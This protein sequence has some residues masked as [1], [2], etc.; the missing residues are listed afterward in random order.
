MMKKWL[1]VPALLLLTSC[2]ATEKSSFEPVVLYRNET[3]DGIK[4]G[5]KIAVE[6]KTITYEGQSKVVNGEIITPD[7]SCKVGKVFEIEMP[8]IYEVRYRAFFGTHEEKISIFYHCHRTSGDFFIPSDKNNPALSGEYSHPVNTGVIK[9]AKLLLDSKTT[10]TYDG[11]IDF[12][13]LDPNKS[14]IEFIVDTSKQETSDLESFTVRLTDTE[15]PNNYIDI[16]IGDSGPVDDSGAGSYWKAGSNNQFKTGY[17]GGREGKIWDSSSKYGTNVGMS[18]RDLP[19]KGANVAKLYFDYPERE[20]YVYPLINSTNKGIITDLDDKEIYGSNVWEGFKSGK[21]TVS[22]FANSLLSNYATLIVTKIGSI[23]LSPL[24]FIDNDAPI[25]KVNYEGQST[26]NVPMAAIDKPYKIFKATVSDNFDRRLSC[27]TYVTY[28]DEVHHMTKDIT[29]TDGYFTPKE[30]GQYTITYVA[31][32]H[33]NNYAE[34]TV[35]VYA[36]NDLQDIAIT[37]DEDEI[38]Q[39]IYSVVELP[40]IEEVKEKVTG[41]SGKPSLERHVFD[42]NEEEIEIEGNSFVPTEV[43]TYKAIY[44]AVDYIGNE[45]S[46]T[47]TI[48]V[49]NPGH[50][51]FIE[52]FSLPKILIKGHK[53]T[54]PS[55][56][57]AEVVNNETVYLNSNVYVN[58]VLLENNE[59]VAGDICS[60]EYE[61]DGVS[62]KEYYYDSIDVVDVSGPE[63]GE[64]KLENYFYG[65]FVPEV[66]KNDVV[67][68]ASSGD[69]ASSIFASP[70]PHDILNF[71]FGVDE[72]LFNADEL[73]FKVSDSTNHNNSLSFRF[74]IE[75]GVPYISIGSDP[76]KYE[77]SV[78]DNTYLIEFTTY[79]RTLKDIFHKNIAVVKNNDQGNPFTGFGGGV[80]LEIFMK[81]IASESSFKMLTIANQSLGD[82]G[83]NPY[84]DT[85]KP[86]VA[87]KEDFLFEQDYMTEAFLPIAEAFD[88]LSDVSVTITVKAPNK[89]VII[90]N[91]DATVRH[92]FI[93]DKFGSYIVTYTATDSAGKVGTSRRLITVYDI[94]PPELTIQGTLKETY[95]LNAKI[96]IPSYEVNDNLNDYT[97]DVFLIMPN[98][99]QRL[100][101]TDENGDVTSYLSDDSLYYN[102]SFRVD[103]KT[104]RAEQRGHY[105]LRYVAYDA[106][107]NK[108]VKELHFEVK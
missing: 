18:F 64:L 69:Q 67:L 37:L 68:T 76:T 49:T 84:K 63:E 66:N 88:V 74:S 92:S 40:S 2:Y 86:Q 77:F 70:L 80:Y 52:E 62:G 90:D 45:C 59:F 50:P 4:I 85:V 30:E 8:G 102:A 65:D 60:V 20:L 82:K 105:T 83:K 38:T 16:N 103:E 39:D 12:S 41:G 48:H 101:L 6:P 14:F 17:E 91:Q 72:E 47:L 51:V 10:F 22:I 26:I 55:A 28:Y 108:V 9:G 35:D 19:D 36:T 25:I 96:T 44:T 27:S 3:I 33:S 71:E 5:D 81:N 31:K 34:K 89:Q 73:V 24:D 95:K 32:D 57:G 97:V 106:D 107:F 29:V 13:S 7:G 53:Y 54:L 42:R 100:L 15:D 58:D 104:F 79:N 94:V 78:E 11:E 1:I 99:E 23:D 46:A 75:D 87:L 56:I 61:L 93:L 98:N 43:G 21:A